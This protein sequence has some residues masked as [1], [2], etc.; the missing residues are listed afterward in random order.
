LAVGVY[1][2]IIGDL[3]K[4]ALVGTILPLAY[5]F[6]NMFK[7]KV[8]LITGSSQGIGKAIALKFAS[9]GAKSR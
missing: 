7:D 4:I 8:I 6:K 3:L 1:P 2:F 5:R 9:S